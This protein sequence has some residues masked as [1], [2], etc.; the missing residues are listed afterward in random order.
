MMVK[1]K[2]FTKYIAGTE[3]LA[4]AIGNGGLA[5][6]GIVGSDGLIDKHMERDSL[7][8]RVMA[9]YPLR[10]NRNRLDTLYSLTQPD[11]TAELTYFFHPDHLGSASWITDLSGQ[12]VQ[13]L[14]YKPF[15]GDYIDQ[16]DPN[17]EYSE[18]FRFTGKERD[19]ET[20]Y[21]YFGARYYSSSL[22]IWLSVDPMSDKYPSLS[23][24]VYC[25]D[26]PMRLVDT[27][28]KEIVIVGDK[29][30]QDKIKA[31][32]KEL[33]NSGKAG[34]FLVNQ[35]IKSNRTFVIANTKV[36]VKTELSENNNATVLPFNIA[37]S[38]GTYNEDNG[39]V[40]YT[41][42]T[43]LA[44]ELA[45]FN[46]P[47]KGTLLNENN[48][49]TRIRAGEVNAVE[50]ENRVRK[51]LGLSERKKYG[52]LSVYGKSI[53]ESSKYSGFYSLQ[54]NSNYGNNDFSIPLYGNPSVS[55]ERRKAYY[56][57]GRFF[58]SKL[59]NPSYMYQIRIKY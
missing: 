42:L 35:A 41:P 1:R 56:I 18:R 23:P 15:G 49:D 50:W 16:Q 38:T 46:F 7:L 27:E 48:Q 11:T 59:Q 19:A 6:I 57:H 45:H 2:S 33:R 32:L 52:G 24:Y 21:D 44:H 53:I 25:A 37:N 54:N 14:Q 34:A 4:S 20:G 9:P 40:P 3:R 47:Q 28:G 8:R 36:D 29:Q 22:G 10:I 13:H 43:I 58:D 55:Q 39:S 5:D 51:D 12:P 17:T 26:N 30:Y 31:Y